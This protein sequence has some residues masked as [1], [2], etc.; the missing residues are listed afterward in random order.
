[1]HTSPLHTHRDAGHGADRGIAVLDFAHADNQ[2]TN[3]H[4][5]TTLDEFT[6]ARVQRLWEDWLRTS[7]PEERNKHRFH[8]NVVKRTTGLEGVR[9]AT[10]Y[11]LL[12]RYDA[13]LASR[14]SPA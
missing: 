11:V 9:L 6:V 14:L 2:D 7:P 1:M 5:A 4:Q 8:Q 10:V 3:I 12:A 13:T